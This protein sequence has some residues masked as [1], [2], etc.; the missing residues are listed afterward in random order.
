MKEGT[1]STCEGTKCPNKSRFCF[2]DCSDNDGD[3]CDNYH[4]DSD[5]DDD[6]D[7]DDG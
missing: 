6:D 7:D 1:Q 2:A 5:D 3:D 4:I